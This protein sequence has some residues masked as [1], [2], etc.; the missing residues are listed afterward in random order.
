M[1]AI[2]LDGTH[3]LPTRPIWRAGST[4]LTRET[5]VRTGRLCASVLIFAPSVALT[6]CDRSTEL[7]G[8]PSFPEAVQQAAVAAQAKAR[9]KSAYTYGLSRPE[10]EPIEPT[11]EAILSAFTASDRRDM[12]ERLGTLDARA[13]DPMLE[14]L[15]DDSVR[16]VY[17]DVVA[18]NLIRIV[19]LPDPFRHAGVIGFPPIELRPVTPDAGRVTDAVLAYCRA[20]PPKYGSMISSLTE[21]APIDRLPAI[22]DFAETCSNEQSQAAAIRLFSTFTHT[23]FATIP[24][25]F[26][27]NSS[28]ESIAHAIEDGRARQRESLVKMREWWGEHGK[29]PY[30]AWAIAGVRRLISDYK[31]LLEED[32]PLDCKED[33]DPDG[34]RWQ[35]RSDWQRANSRFGPSVFATLVEAFHDEPDFIKPFVLGLIAMTQHPD[36]RAFVAKQLSSPDANLRFVAVEQWRAVGDGQRL[37]DVQRV[38]DTA[39]DDKPLR[40]EATKTLEALKLEAK[41]EKVVDAVAATGEDVA[42]TSA[43]MALIRPYARSG[44]ER[45]RQLADARPDP[46]V[47]NKLRR[48]LAQ[49]QVEAETPA[50]FD[51]QARLAAVRSKLRSGDWKSLQSAAS[52]VGNEELVELVPEV[53]PLI[54]NQYCAVSEE[55]ARTLIK[56]GIPDLTVENA[57]RLMGNSLK[58]DRQIAAYCYDRYGRAA[59]PL[60]ERA[61]FELRDPCMRQ[62]QVGEPAPGLLRVLLDEHVPGVA[63]RIRRLALDHRTWDWYMGL[64]ALIDDPETASVVENLLANRDPRVQQNAIRLA[65]HLELASCA[66]QLVE[67]ANNADVQALKAAAKKCNEDPARLSECHA[68]WDK[69]NSVEHRPFLATMA[70]VAL[71]DPRAW[72]A[73]VQLMQTHD[74]DWRRQDSMSGRRTTQ[75]AFRLADHKSVFHDAMRGALHEEL[76]GEHRYWIVETLTVALSLNPDAVDADVL[77]EVVRQE[78]SREDVRVLALVALSKLSDPRALPV[79]RDTVRKALK[80]SVE[81]GEAGL[82][83]FN[84][85]PH[86]EPKPRVYA[87]PLLDRRWPLGWVWPRFEEH[88]VDPAMALARYGDETLVD[89]ALDSL[90]T[91]RGEFNQ[92]AYAVLNRLVGANSLELARARLASSDPDLLFVLDHYA[93][94]TDLEPDPAH[95][96]RLLERSDL[97]FYAVRDLLAA[98]RYA[99]AGDQLVAL[100]KRGSAEPKDAW[101]NSQI[102]DVL[103][104]IGDPRGLALAADDI[105][106]FADAAYY[107]HGGPAVW[108]AKGSFKYDRIE[109]AQALRSWYRAH[110]DEL[111]FDQ[112]RGGFVAAH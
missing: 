15:A 38:I 62:K 55:A 80:K 52:I 35:I 53:I 51:R 93:V 29:E 97:S 19:T 3:E 44:A 75:I 84:V 58:L 31:R 90:V 39:G 26:C 66:D 72:L 76:E 9:A 21:I 34:R 41:L 109:Q 47:R 60:V 105:E 100:L 18:S 110:A 65:G 99:P 106:L 17:R 59:L 107:L 8:W 86:N 61:A 7:N 11:R 87:S 12:Y 30:S 111:K 89:D 10:P 101:R 16:P 108:P 77:W 98:K 6:A 36:A 40:E 32:Y 73:T 82:P 81:S 1:G 70:L 95:A 91:V 28:A 69:V 20:A 85:R 49:A 23:Y 54:A 112:K 42:A 37:E 68:L 56:L 94:I 71:G 2:G 74:L 103:C 46:K 24:M 57:A 79:L 5:M 22:L 33:C 96:L 48:M 64:L 104:Q 25:G 63:R 50:A 4:T 45:L 43:A 102:V 83:Y 27:G 78:A 13:I 92:Y 67:L 14:I 88:Q